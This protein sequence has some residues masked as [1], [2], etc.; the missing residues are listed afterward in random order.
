VLDR[1]IRHEFRA[2]PLGDDLQY[3]QDFDRN[4]ETR[5]EE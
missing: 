3:R 2:V 5:K 1:T 4:L